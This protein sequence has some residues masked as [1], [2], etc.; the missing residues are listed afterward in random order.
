MIID[1]LA[2]CISGL[3]IF[4]DGLNFVVISLIYIS[5]LEIG[6]SSSK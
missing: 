5:G 1:Q 2:F 6:L 4:L 3:Y